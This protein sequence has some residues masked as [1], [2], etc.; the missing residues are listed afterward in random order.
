[1]EKYSKQRL[2]AIA[3]IAAL[4]VIIIPI[5]L[6][7][8]EKVSKPTSQYVEPPKTRMTEKDLKD[9]PVMIASNV[10]M[11][12]SSDDDA[13]VTSDSTDTSSQAADT[14]QQTTPPTVGTEPETAETQP[15]E[16]INSPAQERLKQLQESQVSKQQDLQS[17]TNQ[18]Q[19]QE[20]TTTQEGQSQPPSDQTTTD[21]GQAAEQKQID[22][23]V[24]QSKVKPE[25]PKVK[26]G[27][28]ATAA[29]TPTPAS[30]NAHAWVVQLGSFSEQQHAE[31]LVMKLREKNF[32]AFL[33]KDPRSSHQLTRVY[34]GPEV[35]K[36]EAAAIKV[37]LKQK[38]GM[39]GF[40]R[41]YDVTLI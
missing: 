8:Q 29:D 19:P 20:I 6:D 24:P 5:V 4:A 13:Q 9:Q 1:M 25:T 35:S 14:T 30:A 12:T 31:E 3:V 37:S 41:A 40:V 16:V 39:T 17:A 36:E 18:A 27:V 21:D 33:Y 22:M 26:P 7:Q 11:T 15:V 34:V 28:P 32:S 2:I 38:M 23:L 10:S